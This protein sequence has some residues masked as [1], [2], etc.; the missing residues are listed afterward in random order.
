MWKVLEVSRNT[1]L[2]SSGGLQSN[3]MWIS[4]VIDSSCETQE[5]PGIK[6]DWKYVN[7][8][9]LTKKLKGALKISLSNILLN[10][11]NRLIG[12]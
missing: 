9:F 2:T 10:I 3:D 12:L 11:G 6:L 8:W 1:P 7:N 4:W 5:S